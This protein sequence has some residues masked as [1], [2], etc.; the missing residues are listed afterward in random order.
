MPNIFS[1][2]KSG[3]NAARVGFEVTG[4][5]IANVNTQGYNRQVI[6]QETRQP[7]KETFGFLGT[8]GDVAQILRCYDRYLDNQ[9]LT[10]QTQNNFYTSQLQILNQ[11]DNLVGDPTISL[12][13]AIQGVFSAMQK[14]S[15]DPSSIPARQVVLSAAQSMTEKFQTLDNRLA[16]IGNGINGQITTSVGSINGLA[17]E[18]AELNKR[19]LEFSAGSQTA[20]PN[21]LMDKRDFAMQQLNKLVKADK[22]MA[23]DGSYS[24]FIGKGQSLVLGDITFQLATQPDPANPQNVQLIT[25]SP[26]GG[27]PTV[28]P[29]EVITGGDL[30]GWFAVRNGVLNQVR[31]DLGNIA[32]DLTTA[33]NYQQQLGVDLNGNGAPPNPAVQAVF[34]NLTAYATN[35]QQ[36]VAAMNVILG[37]PRGIACASNM[38]V[39][40][41]VANGNGVVVTKVAASLPGNY[42]WTS[43]NTPPDYTQHP[44][45]GMTNIVVNGTTATITGGPQP[46]NYDVVA[47]PSSQN[48][49]KLVTQAVPPQDAGITFTLSGQLQNAM[50]FTITPNI[51]TTFGQGDNGNLL[52]T[53]QLQTATLVDSQRNGTGYANRPSFQTAYAVTVSYV[54][55]TTS[56]TQLASG[57]AAT[58]LKESV[59]I[60]SN[61]SGVNLDEEAANLLRY[62]QAYFAAGK[63]IE[64]ANTTFNQVLQ[65]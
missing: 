4:H 27:P 62:Q 36:A 47:D 8:G 40:G 21:D 13:P 31:T 6:E 50:T 24:V 37:D 63:V 30:G 55:S 38:T 53:L 48:G 11:I 34:S 1:I 5:N 35:P 56:N 16:E 57:A 54:G 9:V 10:A 25:L 64:V 7:Q 22:V 52:Q 39:V 65:L 61:A 59:L 18:I 15:Q 44:S 3:L 14:L 41:P 45:Y 42:G 49:Y 20:L 19:I 32:I 12:N 29:D 46:G 60:R 28:I 43:P 51:A 26:S 17:Q 33:F 2:G 58:V 23:A